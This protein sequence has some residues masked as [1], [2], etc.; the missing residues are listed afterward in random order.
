MRRRNRE[1]NIFSLSML[2]VI[3]GAMGA[4]LIIMIVLMP[5]YRREHIDYQAENA[6][7][8][9]QLTEAARWA[10]AA[11]TRAAAADEAAREA[12]AAA[13][14]ARDQAEQQV[15]EQRQRADALA[16]KLAKTFLVIYVRWN[17]LDDVDLH[18]IDPSGAEF[19]FTMKKIPGRPGELSEDTQIGPGTEVW[20]V[21]DAP[22]GEYQVY[23]RLYAD[24]DSRKPASVQGRIFHRD[25]SDSLPAA[26]LNQKGDAVR[27]A[28]IRI[29]A[30]GNVSVR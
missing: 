23:V 5:Y 8:R 9:D 3:S 13:A 22:P 1:I 21:R 28:T 29:N 6:A 17:T 16:R 12:Q 26:P 14:S 10:E 19:D 18:V 15:E 25:G 30:E 20:E 27:L 11:E 4:F 7:L 2:D 24:R